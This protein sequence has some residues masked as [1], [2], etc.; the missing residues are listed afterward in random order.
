[1]LIIKIVTLHNFTLYVKSC[2]IYLAKISPKSKTFVYLPKLLIMATIYYSLSNKINPLGQSEIYIRFSHGKINQRAKTGLFVHPAYWSEGAVKIPNFRLKP[3]KDVQAEIDNAIQVQHRLAQVT[4]LVIRSFNEFLRENISSNWL[5]DLVEGPA[6]SEKEKTIWQYFDDYL[7]SRPISA[8]RIRTYKVIIRALKRFELYKRLKNRSFILTMENLSDIEIVNEFEKYFRNEPYL[9][10]SANLYEQVAES[11][12]P[13]ERGQN[14]VTC[15]MIMLRAFLNWA[16][17]NEF[18]ERNPFQ[19]RRIAPAVYGTPIYITIEERNRLQNTNLS[20]HRWI[21]IQRDIFIFQCL[22]GCRVGDLLQLKRSNIVNGAIEYIPR[23]TKEGHPVT[24]RVPLNKIAKDIIS[25]YEDETRKSLLPFISP[26]KYNVAIKRAFMAA[27]LKR[28]VQVLNQITREPE[29]KPL[30]EVASS[31]MAR[32]TFIGNLYKQ[33]KDPNLI[34][35][36][37]GHVEGSS[38]FS[39][40][41]DIDEEMKA[42]LVKLLE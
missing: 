23:K 34:A 38:A 1:M 8:G 28:P 10:E 4:A 2:K 39:R 12:V 19:K 32:R 15:K 6:I 21:S 41:R 13:H 31:H 5:R 22:I 30:Y 36:L 9:A 20:R 29:M 42:D 24:V 37:S 40:Y 25:K 33:V 35:Q 14:T 27:R 16:F 18:I 7:E 11:K 17:A 3:T 26:Q